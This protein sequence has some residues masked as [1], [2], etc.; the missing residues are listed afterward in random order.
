MNPYASPSPPVYAPEDE[1]L[2]CSRYHKTIKF[3]SFW[4]FALC[5]ISI[6]WLAMMPILGVVKLAML[7]PQ[8]F[9]SGDTFTFPAGYLII[10]A[11][12]TVTACF[13]FLAMLVCFF[14]SDRL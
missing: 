10:A 9:Q 4:T 8:S 5:V 11:G 6:F 2:K 14:L 12:L 3:L 13:S 1:Q 7:N